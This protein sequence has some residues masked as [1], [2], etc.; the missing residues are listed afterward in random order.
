MENLNA[1]S[2]IP[3]LAS[4][5]IRDNPVLTNCCGIYEPLQIGITGPPSALIISGNPFACGSEA[6]ILDNCA[7]VGIDLELNLSTINLNPTIYSSTSLTL[8]IANKGGEAATGVVV[9]FAKPNST[10]Y[11]GGN[12]FT[13]SQGSFDPFGNEEWNIGDLAAGESATLGVNYFYLT[14]DALTPYAQV[15]A[16]NEPDVDSAPGNGTCCTPLEDDE[17]TILL[18]GLNGGGSI[19]FAADLGRLRMFFDEI[20]P[21]PVKYW[22][23]FDI[24]SPEPQ[25]ALIDF[26]DVTGRSI[27]RMEVELSA[28]QN[29]LQ[30]DVSNWRSGTYTLIARGEGHPAYGRF[31]K[32]WE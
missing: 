23:N 25:T 18:N 30:L 28:G 11:T 17:A 8:T 14:A 4:V 24:Y 9:H 6:D 7:P 21:N 16:Q 31:L 2:N 5:L 22:V 15:V 29:D 20:Y 26:Y 19:S 27:H 1:L 12:E 3:T 32:V 13:A 10:V